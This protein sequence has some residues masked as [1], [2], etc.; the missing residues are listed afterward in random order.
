MRNQSCE[1][2][3]D[4][5]FDSC[6]RKREDVAHMR[7]KSEADFGPKAGSGGPFYLHFY[8]VCLRASEKYT[9]GW[10]VVKHRRK[11]QEK[12]NSRRCCSQEG[13]F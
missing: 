5:V 11:T 12:K 1:I 13:H 7:S 10:E 2:R 8:R 4:Q 6:T 3:C 9:F